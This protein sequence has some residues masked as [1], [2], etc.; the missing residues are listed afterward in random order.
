MKRRLMWLFAPL[1]GATLA[2][3]AMNAQ[4]APKEQA[5]MRVVL[6]EPNDEI[7]AKRIID[8]VT[9]ELAKS[10]I[11]EETK[12]RILK[13]VEEAMGEAK[14]AAKMALGSA[15]KDKASVEVEL[16]AIQNRIGSPSF[17]GAFTTQLFRDPK[18]EGY[19]IGVQCSQSEHE[20]EEG[21]IESEPGLE[22][23]AV[24]EDSPAKKAGIEEGDVLIS[25]NS[26]KIMKIVDLTSALQEAGKN[27]K[28]VAIELKR[29]D[30]VLSINVTPI[31]MKS[32]DIELENI[33]LSL[34]T[35]GY[36]V[37]EQVM[38]SLQEQMK[39]LGS[40]GVGSVSPNAGAQVWSFKG[41]SAELRKD[42]VEL[43]SE[44]AE[45]KKMIKE[46]AGKK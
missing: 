30:K 3:S 24:F 6:S 27:E 32:S 43:K 10:G 35:G 17:S 38:K 37:D 31:K 22:V 2:T 20:N 14:D 23:K 36:V 7:D 15:S 16:K 1:V 44:M 19:R 41:E 26:S 5:R 21:K 12:S 4:D 46:M 29:D 8:K 28:S 34:P 9:K 42:M 45:L 18:N 13:N 39:K 33:R 11:S 40:S 25:V